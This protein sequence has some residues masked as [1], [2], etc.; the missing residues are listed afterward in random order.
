[1]NGQSYF[2]APLRARQNTELAMMNRIVSTTGATA[3]L[4]QHDAEVLTDGGKTAQIIL[5]EQVYTLRITRAG[6][7]ILTK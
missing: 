7:L 2:G 6:K 5:G 4:P 3:A 1:M